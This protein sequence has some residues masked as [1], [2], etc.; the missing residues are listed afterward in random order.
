VLFY[1]RG[2]PMLL[3][4]S[5]D[6]VELE[7]GAD[8]GG[9]HP[10]A[11]ADSQAPVGAYGVTR[12]GGSEVVV[13]DLAADEV[14]ATH[15]VPGGTVID[16]IDGGVVF[17]RTEDGTTTWDSRTDGEQELAGPQTSVADARNGVILYDG[18]TPRGPAAAAYRLVKGAIDAQLTFDGGHV[19]YWSST[20]ESTDGGAPVVLD[21]GATRPGPTTGWWAVDIDG[22]ILTAVPG[23]GN[24]NTVY[25]C[26]VPSGACTGLGPLTTEHGDPEFIGVDM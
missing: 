16:G 1:D 9:F 12:D 13:R 6:V 11:K 10:T 8:K 17:L 25:D 21:A 19:L 24:T 2:R 22:S 14:V 3:D 23:P 20:L 18:P 7:P 4:E 15:T 5:G 26:E